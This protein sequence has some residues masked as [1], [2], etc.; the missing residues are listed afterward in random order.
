MRNR[1]TI[2]TIKLPD[3]AL[4]LL[5][6]ASGSGKSSFGRA[7]FK[8]TEVI[9]SDTCRGW[10]ADDEND[11]TATGAAF[12]VLH[13]IAE[14]RL[15]AR[16][17]TVIDATN[18][19]AED[20]RSL[21]ALAKKHYAQCV[22][23]VL[24]PDESVCHERNALRPN[25]QFGPHV[26]RNQTR[27]MKQGINSLGREGFRYVYELRSVAEIQQV[28]VYRERLWTDRRDETGSFDI[29]G[30]IHGC[31]D[32]LMSLLAELGYETGSD[33]AG[34]YAIPPAGRKL[35]F[36]GD[37]VDRGP[38]TPQVLRL[39]M[40]MIAAGRALCVL[41]NHEAK[42]LKWLQGRQVKMTHGLAESAAQLQQESEEFRAEV[43]KFLNSLISHY[44]LDEGRLAVAHA[45]IKENMLARASGVI[46]QFCMY[47]ETTG[48][49]DEF[50]LPVR[51]SWA[52]DY[53]GD[54]KIIY[55]HTPMPA[56]EWLNNTLC[57]DTGCVF[58]G[59]LSALRY[60]EMSLVAVSAQQ[61]Y[62][63]PVKPLHLP[64]K[65][66]SA[67]QV[68]DDVLDYADVSGKRLIHTRLRDQIT[69]Y[70][71]NAAAALEVMSRFAVNPRWL[72][73]LPPTMAPTA[74]SQVAGYLEHPH[75]AF[76]Y[77]AKQAVNEVICE[78]KHMGSRAVIVVCRSEEAAQQ[79]FGVQ[80]G[81]LGVIYTRTGRHF[82]K[83]AALT[84][85]L[86]ERL[87]QALEKAG[88]WDSLQSD[89]VCLDAE[90]MPWSAKA[91]SLIAE[92]YAPVG[93]AAQLGLSA[94]NQALQ[95]AQQRGVPVDEL[96]SRFVQREQAAQQY[97]AAWQHY[98]W[99]V[100]SLDDLRIAPFH[101]LASE[102]AVHDQQTHAWHMQQLA[103]LA[104]HDNLFVATPYRVLSPADET[105]VQAACD[106]WEQ[107]TAQGGEGM[108]V[109]SN[110]F[111]AYAN[112]QLVQP[113][114]KCRGREYLRIIYGPEY[115]LPE[116][117][118]RLRKRGLGRKQS[119]AMREFALGHEALHRFVGK[120]ALRRVHE[121]VF[122][123][124]ALESEPVDPRL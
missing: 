65:L 69:V 93:E 5:I 64:E 53:R 60:P 54:T 124:L 67:Q 18:V 14:K 9:S 37:L 87:N 109:K 50:G 56:A 86:L 85:A 71:E 77:Y 68:H 99:P 32:E 62:C 96:A 84:R 51:Y 114:L 115:D 104:A 28:Q 42:L 47:G 97:A 81:E 113:A 55:G 35:I 70:G 107:L 52:M 38:K 105:A 74:T 1:K 39:A 49:T 66:P 58:G 59:K 80:A 120:E 4:V 17:L 79:R 29:V 103:T 83:D 34:E 78:V 98:C 102:G 6:G 13:Y 19:R 43:A 23:I 24:N 122:G 15:A 45:G 95:Q 46:K 82:F 110:S 111:L 108:V 26:V 33:A 2:E 118:E 72:I 112:G 25:R 91:S 121:C 31:F 11:Q 75:E 61:V 88:L 73:Y 22:A 123:V 90:I 44:L 92:Q 48:E 16:R 76:S 119:L 30:D 116:H 117:L 101:L 94:V 63:E 27:A 7:H 36:V 106:W 89:W 8:P 10:V 40:R 21:V 12:E 100:H 57:V 3:F 41:G 20:R